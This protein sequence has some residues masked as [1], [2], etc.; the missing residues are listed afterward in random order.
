LFARAIHE[1][2][3]VWGGEGLYPTI[4]DALHALDDGIKDYMQENGWE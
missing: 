1:G 2:G 4:D 3:L